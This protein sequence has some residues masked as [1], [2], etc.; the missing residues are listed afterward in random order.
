MSVSPT[1]LCFLAAFCRPGDVGTALRDLLLDT[2]IVLPCDLT[3]SERDEICELVA[4]FAGLPVHIAARPPDLPTGHV[5]ILLEGVDEEPA[6]PDGAIVLAVRSASPG[7][8]RLGASQALRDVRGILLRAVAGCSPGTR[9]NDIALW[10]EELTDSPPMGLRFAAAA[11]AADICRPHQSDA[12]LIIAGLAEVLA[13]LL[14]GVDSRVAEWVLA[15]ALPIARP[16]RLVGTDAALMGEHAA[17][18]RALTAGLV[19]HLPEPGVDEVLDL[20][21]PFAVLRLPDDLAAPLDWRAFAAQ[22]EPRV[23][24]R[25]HALLDRWLDLRPQPLDLPRPLPPSTFVGRDDLL[26]RLR[27]LI[28]PG[29]EIRTTVVYG[30]AGVGKTAL[31]AKL[32]ANLAGHTESLWLSFAE[33]PESAWKRVADALA[34]AAAPSRLSTLDGITLD[35]RLGPRERTGVDDDAAPGG[36]GTPAWLR[37]V[38][39][40]IAERDLLI[41]IDDADHVD[42]AALPRW[43]PR[44]TSARRS[45][46]SAWFN[47]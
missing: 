17:L 43:L 44:A 23:H 27:V 30:L 32:C 28:E 25:I 10:A 19:E 24:P 7:R 14:R 42:E 4:L 34:P 18:Q 37:H 13:C 16:E 15:R 31:A 41:V 9:L 40:R 29:P 5:I 2:A 45:P 11:H 22:L 6:V 47:P 36:D 38:H 26:T 33:G 35:R 20:R 3:E 12:D 1:N 8:R 46:A 21:R 39:E